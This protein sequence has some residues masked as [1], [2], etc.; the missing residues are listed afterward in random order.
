MGF[1]KNYAS[2]FFGRPANEA[3]NIEE[4]ILSGSHIF[5][6]THAEILVVQTYELH[7]V[8]RQQLKRLPT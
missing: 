6:T 8:M 7:R 3:Y 1:H 4:C 5:G 2:L